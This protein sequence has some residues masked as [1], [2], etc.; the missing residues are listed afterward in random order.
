[1]FLKSLFVTFVGLAVLLT[2]FPREVMAVASQKKGNQLS[3]NRVL[4]NAFLGRKSEVATSL[5]KKIEKKKFH[6]GSFFKGEVPEIKGIA[7]DLKKFEFHITEVPSGFEVTATRGDQKVSTKIEFVDPLARVVRIDGINV[8]FQKGLNYGQAYQGVA[9]ILLRHFIKE[10]KRK[11]TGFYENPLNFFIQEAYAQEESEYRYVRPD[12]IPEPYE[13][14][15]NQ[16][17][18]K[19]SVLATSAVGAGLDFIA[20]APAA[21]AALGGTAA[22]VVAG[23]AGGVA[24]GVAVGAIAAATSSGVAGAVAGAVV[25]LGLS[26]LAIFLIDQVKLGRTKIDDLEKLGGGLND[27]LASCEEGKEEYYVGE[28][29][30]RANLGKIEELEELGRSMNPHVLGR[31]GKG[32]EFKKLHA[33]QQLWGAVANSKQG[34]EEEGATLGCGS[35]TGKA[36][37]ESLSREVG[38]NKAASAIRAICRVYEGIYN[39]FSS[40]PQPYGEKGFTNEGAISGDMILRERGDIYWDFY[41]SVG[42]GSIGR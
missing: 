35:L 3:V 42:E 28:E 34:F 12:G 17:V 32:I 9:L 29:H 10:K 21:T 16:A 40:V 41:Q 20:F 13:R 37:L 14:L 15:W 11:K 39:C 33:F 18:N 27:L 22:V 1:M 7:R 4:Y 6:K 31:R 8:Q 38:S 26:G 23:V 30:S 24:G 19:T 25:L 36:G 5:R 2:G